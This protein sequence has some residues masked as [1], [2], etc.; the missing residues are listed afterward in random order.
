MLNTPVCRVPAT[1]TRQRSWP[2]AALL[3]LGAW[4]L[5]GLLQAYDYP[6]EDPY[7]A[8]IIGTPKALQA[9]LP[10]SI[11]VETRSL[12]AVVGR[13][14]PRVL[15]YDATLEYSLALQPGEAPL[16]FVI[17]GTGGVH[18][19]SSN[20]LLMRGF[21]Q[22][23]FHVVGLT[24]PSHPKFVVAASS[25]RVPGQLDNDAKDLY[26]VMGQ[27]RSALE[28]E[29]VAVSDWSVTGYSLGAANAA[30]VGHLDSQRH[31]FDF[32]KVLLIN[33]PYSLYNS[34]SKLDRMLENIPGGVDNFN[35][36]FQQLVNRVSKAYKRSD[37]VEFNEALIYEAFKDDPPTDEQLAAI[38][39][40]AFRLMS[41]NMVMTVDVMTDFGLIKPR[42]VTLTKFTE[43]DAYFRVAMRLNFT[44]YYHELFYP[45]YHRRDPAL[46]R[47]SLAD[48]S[49]LEA[50]GDYLRTAG[51]VGL[52]GNRDDII[53][54]PG[55][56][57]RLQ[58][59]FGDR[60][61]IY[62]RGG[63]LGNMAQ[64]ETLGYIVDWFRE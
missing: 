26:R 45:F 34:M 24:S 9:E 59:L 46:T 27:I 61:R 22:A 1:E 6:I 53:L 36:F 4:L 29:G 64:Y 25:T 50:I 38:I 5:P 3:L 48:L 37:S 42:N 49:S 19:T 63:H 11:P 14:I 8:T 54:G 17:A 20:L 57:D 35:A 58:A 28:Q 18:N 12:Q 15:S 23:G 33:P 56:I 39:G 52:V 2:W 60:A 16:I 43:M 55:E 21:F 30:F 51:N 31:L 10:E 32:R 40:A 44:D 62:P 41:A 13:S 47:E 7:A